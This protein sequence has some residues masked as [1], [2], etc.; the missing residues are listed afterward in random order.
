MSGHPYISII[1]VMIIIKIQPASQPN[2]PAQEACQPALHSLTPSFRL[3][4]QRWS[5][6]CLSA[7]PLANFKTCMQAPAG[8]QVTRGSA[9]ALP[10]HLPIII[11][12]TIKDIMN[13]TN[14]QNNQHDTNTYDTTDNT[15]TNTTQ[16]IYITMTHLNIK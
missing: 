11:R 16:H 7:L 14:T 5:C 9:A 15:E 6:Q 4:R 13:D 1:I 2:Q 8:K 3:S 12:I 10:P